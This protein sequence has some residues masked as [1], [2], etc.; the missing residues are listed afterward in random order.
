M[1]GF[2]TSCC[3]A[4]DA[5]SRAEEWEHFRT[6]CMNYSKSPRKGVSLW[7]DDD[8]ADLTFE[9]EDGKLTKFTQY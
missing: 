8:I 4:D 6:E 2:A 5:I 1:I 3:N 7:I 9:F